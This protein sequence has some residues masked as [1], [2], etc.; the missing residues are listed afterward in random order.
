MRNLR[1]NILSKDGT[2]LLHCGILCEELEK[3]L[4]YEIL[5][6]AITGNVITIIIDYK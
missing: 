1:Y 5:S 6:K 2:P 4:D 3:Y